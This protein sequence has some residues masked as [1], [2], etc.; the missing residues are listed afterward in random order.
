MTTAKMDNQ[1]RQHNAKGINTLIVH[2]FIYSIAVQLQGHKEKQ[3][4]EAE[5]FPVFRELIV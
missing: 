5:V 2:L 4:G 1:H 3:D